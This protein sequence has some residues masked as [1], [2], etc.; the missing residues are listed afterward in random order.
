MSASGHGPVATDYPE[1]AEGAQ[2]LEGFNKNM[3]LEY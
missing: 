3:S 1:G 2:S